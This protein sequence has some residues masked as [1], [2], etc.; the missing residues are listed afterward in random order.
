MESKPVISAIAEI[1]LLCWNT[2]NEN[3]LAI[4]QDFITDSMVIELEKP[5]K[6]KTVELRK[7][8]KI[9]LPD[10][11]IAATALVYN[12]ILVSRNINDFK[13]IDGLQ[14]VNPFDH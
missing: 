8:Y 14:V 1:E 9:K 4:I 2:P 7:L 11:I 5:I 10:A 3:D 13:K 6:Q 12:L